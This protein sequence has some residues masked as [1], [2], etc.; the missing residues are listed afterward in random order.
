MIIF[1]WVF[2]C[3]RYNSNLQTPTTHEDEQG[4]LSPDEQQIS[5]W[6]IGYL[7]CLLAPTSIWGL[8]FPEKWPRHIPKTVYGWLV[9]DLWVGG[10]HCVSSAFRTWHLDSFPPS[11]LAKANVLSPPPSYHM[12]HYRLPLYCWQPVQSPPV[13]DVCRFHLPSISWSFP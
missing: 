2:I 10:Y 7:D 8:M 12:A 13:V 5:G 4:V 11:S 1:F 6:R 3:T 9:R